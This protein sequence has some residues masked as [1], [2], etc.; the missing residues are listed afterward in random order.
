MSNYTSVHAIGN[1]PPAQIV[2]DVDGQRIQF[3]PVDVADADLLAEL[4]QRL[5]TASTVTVGTWELIAQ[6]PDAARR[7]L[8]AVLAAANGCQVSYCISGDGRRFVDAFDATLSLRLDPMDLRE[9]ASL[10]NL[11]VITASLLPT[12]AA[13]A[14]AKRMK[15]WQQLHNVPSDSVSSIARRIREEGNTA[16]ESEPLTPQRAADL[17]LARLQQVREQRGEDTSLSPPERYWKGDDHR[18]DGRYWPRDESF[19]GEVVRILQ[20]EVEGVPLTKN[21]ISSTLANIRAKV[22]LCAENIRTPLFVRAERPPICAERHVIVFQNG[23]VDL[24]EAV[25][26][27]QRPTFYA[28]HPLLFT[29]SM[30]PYAYDPSAICGSRR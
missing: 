15:D 19:E 27:G 11:A 1:Q 2:L 23:V 29:T 16:P 25:Q 9:I 22:E 24:D 10:L 17:V 4:G 13:V 6:L 18:W 12:A 14:A 20:D 3:A 8:V 30:L 26:R 21:F 5:S 28:H 7:Q